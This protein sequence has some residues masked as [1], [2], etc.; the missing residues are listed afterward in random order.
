MGVGRVFFF[1]APRRS[2]VALA[3]CRSLFAVLAHD[4]VK[5]WPTLVLIDDAL[6]SAT[7]SASAISVTELG[8]LSFLANIINL[9]LGICD[10]DWRGVRWMC[11]DCA[12]GRGPIARARNLDRDA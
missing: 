3:L 11:R 4:T 1:A 12:R 7:R 10:G 2:V 6:V 8:P 5:F 9:N